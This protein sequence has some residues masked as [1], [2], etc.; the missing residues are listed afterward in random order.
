MLEAGVPSR[1]MRGFVLGWLVFAS[2]FAVAG[3]DTGVVYASSGTVTAELSRKQRPL[4]QGDPIFVNDRIVTGD[5]SFVVLQFV[6]GARLTILANSAVLIERY[7]Y[8]EAAQDA[9]IV[10][11]EAGGLRIIAG[12]MAKS[13]PEGFKVRTPVALMVVRGAEFAMKLC[14]DQIC[15]EDET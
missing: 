6:D 5:K 9:A 11:L 13:N 2:G 1:V 10:S 12:A 8:Q 15:T 4:Q 14:G 7:R 3:G